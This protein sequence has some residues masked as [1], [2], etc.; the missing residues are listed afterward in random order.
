MK[1]SPLLFI[2]GHMRFG[3]LLVT[4]FALNAQFDSG[5]VPE[6]PRF[7][8]TLVQVK[9]ACKVF[10]GGETWIGAKTTAGGQIKARVS[11]GGPALALRGAIRFHF[12]NGTSFDNSWHFEA[13]GNYGVPSAVV[14]PTP[15]AFP[16]QAARVAKV[17]VRVEGAYFQD[18]GM[19][20]T[21][22]EEARQNWLRTMESAQAD[23][24]DALALAAKV[25][26]AKFLKAVQKDLIQPGPYMRNTTPTM[27]LE[28]KRQLLES[29]VKLE[30]NYVERLKH[31]KEEFTPSTPIRQPRSSQPRG[32]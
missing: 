7:P 5:L 8:R 14:T 21:E 30:K 3:P 28:F 31:M 25:D 16:A 10:A 4:A 20:G 1:Q 11:E 32:L 6:E 27:N 26:E 24:A 13:L 18:G 9:T 19:C 17:E 22:G 29:P 2:L 15:R 12:V 23:I